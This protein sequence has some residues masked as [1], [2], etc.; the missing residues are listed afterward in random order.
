RR[1]GTLTGYA[2]CGYAGWWYAI[3][4]DV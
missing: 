3:G 4:G 2:R 1:A